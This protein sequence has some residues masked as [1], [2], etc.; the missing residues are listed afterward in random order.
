MPHWMSS[1]M[2]CQISYQMS[3]KMASFEILV[4][5]KCICSPWA[6][7]E[8][9]F[10]LLLLFYQKELSKGFWSFTC[11]FNSKIKLDWSWT[12]FFISLFHEPDLSRDL[13]TKCWTHTKVITW[14]GYVRIKLD[15]LTFSYMTLTVKTHFDTWFWLIFCLDFHLKIRMTIDQFD[16]KIYNMKCWPFI[17]LE[18]NWQ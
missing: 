9:S 17:S 14:H 13:Q 5:V 11:S 3:C 10:L 8:V 7:K 15:L 4:Q 18:I 2:S 16:N 1:Q 12:T 6:L